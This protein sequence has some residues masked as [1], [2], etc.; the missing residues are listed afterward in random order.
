MVDVNNSEIELLARRV[1]DDLGDAKAE[2]AQN[3]AMVEQPYL[4]EN[5]ICDGRVVAYAGNS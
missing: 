5:I 3:R 2:G 4:M 1:K